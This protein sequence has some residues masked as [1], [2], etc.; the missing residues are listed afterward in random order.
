[1]EEDK[2]EVMEIPEEETG[3]SVTE[4][5]TKEI[6]EEVPVVREEKKSIRLRRMEF[7]RSRAQKRRETEDLLLELL[8]LEQ[9]K[10]DRLQRQIDEDLEQAGETEEYSRE[11]KESMTAQIY[12]MHGVSADKLEGMEEYRN[13]YRRGASL[14]LFLLSIV[15]ALLCGV[16][17]GFGSDIC[18]FMLAAT[19]IEGALLTQEKN[20]MRIQG[21]LC[22]ILYF[23]IFPSMLVMFVCYELGYREYA[24]FLP[25]ASVAGTAVLAFG[26]FSYFCYDPYRGTKRRIRKARAQMEDIEKETKR[27][28]KKAKGKP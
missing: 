6:A 9:G 16:L 28:I 10:I 18:L 11:L 26:V 1:M 4:K 27:E 20:Q 5:S 22:R 13:A 21:L 19:G 25:Y 15:M 23:L 8:V 7:L 2:N 17:H 3:E 14:S 12:S 24:L